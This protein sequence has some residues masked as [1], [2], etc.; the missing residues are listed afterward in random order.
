MIFAAVAFISFVIERREI[1]ADIPQ[2]TRFDQRI[3]LLRRQAGR[4]AEHRY[5]KIGGEQRLALIDE[6][7][8]ERRLVIALQKDAFERR[9]ET[10]QL[11]DYLAEEL[12]RHRVV[13]AWR[14]RD[15]AKET[16]LIAGRHRLERDDF[17]KIF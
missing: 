8:V 6:T 12:G 10:S 3:D 13:L 14:D 2:R 17:E 15:G 7:A 9:S 4:V 16:F 5:R 1:D 11:I